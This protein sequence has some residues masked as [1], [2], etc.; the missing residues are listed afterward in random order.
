MF[1]CSATSEG[2]VVGDDVEDE[3]LPRGGLAGKRGDM[4]TS[5]NIQIDI[6]RQIGKQKDRKTDSQT[7]RQEDRQTD[8]QDGQT[9]RQ[10]G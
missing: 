2:T 3:K 6:D 5:T 9:D 7:D 4:Y 8:R 10:D 1:G